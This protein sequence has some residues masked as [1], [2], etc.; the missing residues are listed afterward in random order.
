MHAIGTFIFKDGDVRNT[1]E[2]RSESFKNLFS[3]YLPSATF[4]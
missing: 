4:Y 1:T 2:I 3:F